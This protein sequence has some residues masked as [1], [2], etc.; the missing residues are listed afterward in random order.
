[1]NYAAD[2]GIVATSGLG[3]D[4]ATGV[5]NKKKWVGDYKQNK[6]STAYTAE[7]GSYAVC[8]A[9]GFAIEEPAAAGLFDEQGAQRAAVSSS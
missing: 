9:E 6:G 4:E 1:M 7:H 2:N 8:Q 3:S 5:A